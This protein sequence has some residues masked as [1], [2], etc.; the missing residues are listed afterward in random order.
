ME[1]KERQGGPS[2]FTE[3]FS[4]TAFIKLMMCPI[5]CVRGG[6]EGVR[7]RGA[8]GMVTMMG[9]PRLSW[10]GMARLGSSVDHQNSRI[11]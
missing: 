6:G 8:P 5:I 7:R 11:A 4:K 3:V 2:H 1:R 10:D 9:C